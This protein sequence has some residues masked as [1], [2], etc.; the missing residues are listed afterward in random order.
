[1]EIFLV[2]AL[3]FSIIWTDSRF[4]S[5]DHM[6][7]QLWFW[8]DREFQG[9]SGNSGGGRSSLQAD[10][11]RLYQ[12]VREVFLPFICLCNSNSCGH[13]VCQSQSMSRLTR[14]GCPSWNLYRSVV[15]CPATMSSFFY[16]FCITISTI[17]TNIFD[18][19]YSTPSTFLI[20][21]STTA[22]ISC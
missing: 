1:M 4:Y 10:Q 21:T 19:V 11:A 18:M 3:G 2:F 12:E 15:L 5:S 13:V 20:S 16:F 22:F 7:R 9:F 6:W 17:R 8:Q 14:L